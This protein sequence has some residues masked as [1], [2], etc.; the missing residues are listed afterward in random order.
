MGNMS[1]PQ[2]TQSVRRRASHGGELTSNT[3]HLL[4][5]NIDGLDSKFTCE[6]ASVVCDVIAERKPEL[7][8][9]QEIVKSTW[10]LLLDRLGEAYFLY[11]DDEI[12]TN[13]H[14]FCVLLVRKDSAV[15]PQSGRREILRFPQSQQNRYLI[16]LRVTFRDVPI[17]LLTSH[18]ESLVRYAGERKNQLRTCFGIM[19]EE[20]ASEPRGLSILGG[21][22]NLME[23]ELAQISGLADNFYDAWEYCG[24]EEDQK[25]TWDSSEPR[26]RLD[27]IYCSAGEEVKL[28]PSL[29]QLLG[30]EVMQKCGEVYPSDHLGVWVEFEIQ[31]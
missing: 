16:K 15:T 6:R 17:L 22:L 1:S 9:L 24:S 23:K 12:A 26:F 28:A 4:S 19:K 11:R 20:L 29:F 30:R 5:W 14:Y 21:D 3:L 7:V 13:W 2:V 25:Y 27:R 10:K 8:Y 31:A 18:L